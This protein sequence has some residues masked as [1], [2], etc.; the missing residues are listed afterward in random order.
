MKNKSVTFAA[1]VYK[2]DL[3][4]LY[5]QQ[6]FCGVGISIMCKKGIS[7]K[8]KWILTF[9]HPNDI[10]EKFQ[11]SVNT[12]QKRGNSVQKELTNQTF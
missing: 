8:K 6:G 11:F 10:H 12:M 3:K 5:S 7:M 4:C 2:L 9:S 1:S